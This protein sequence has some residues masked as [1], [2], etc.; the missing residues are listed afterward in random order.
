MC[1]EIEIGT[2]FCCLPRAFLEQ[3]I[4][5]LLIFCYPILCYQVRIG[6]L[7]MSD[8]LIKISSYHYEFGNFS[9]QFCML[10]GYV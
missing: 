6:Q 8:I 4:P 1:Q 5:L 2:S 3:V 9:L 10:C 7:T